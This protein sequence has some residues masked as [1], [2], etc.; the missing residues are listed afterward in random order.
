[1]TRPGW[2][3]MATGLLLACGGPPT[4]AARPLAPSRTAG[5]EHRTGVFRGAGGALLVE[6]SWRP[7]D[8]APRAVLVI[9]HGL[10]D[11]S[12]RYRDFARRLVAR[13]YAVH[14]YD[15]RGHGHS[16]GPRASLDDFGDLTSDLDAFLHRVRRREPGRPIFLMGH[17]VGGAV[18][19]LYA[20]ER[21]PPL[22][23]LILLAPALRVDRPPLAAAA[24]PIAGAL[25]PDL[26]VVD[27]PD[28]LFSRSPEV[29]RGM[30]RDPLV[31]HQVGPA[32]TAAALT[33][34]LE[35]IWRGAD[36]L[37]LPLLGLHGTADQLTSPRGTAEL[38]R[39]ARGRDRT[40]LLYTGLY[41]DLVHEPERV[42]VMLD[43]EHWLDRR[44]RRL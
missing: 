3:L 40:L 17:S 25:L 37:D 20:V 36:R 27:T 38:L 24:T 2:W 12:S 6:Q 13:G 33:R 30:A 19:T 22:A 11:H 15:M 32:R 26:P 16:S 28:E 8:R 9:H 42:Q 35:R 31:Y 18:V 5:I 23:G 4:M 44:A 14:A 39:R 43:I 29:V 1:M 34:A 10:K 21:R 7:V 41:H